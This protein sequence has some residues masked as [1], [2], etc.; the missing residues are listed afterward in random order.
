[1]DLTTTLAGSLMEHFFPA[2]W[3]LAE[4]DHLGAL[5]GSDLTKQAAWWHPQF[6]PV[7]CADYGDFDTLLGH[8]IA[9]EILLARQAGRPLALILP[10]GPM[11]MYRWTVFFRKEWQW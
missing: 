3:D 6:E 8:E 2:G 5:S 10:A 11:G 7:A 1:M 4:I 9:R